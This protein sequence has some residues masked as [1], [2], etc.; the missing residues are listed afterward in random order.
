MG[1]Q[2]RRKIPEQLVKHFRSDIFVFLNQYLRIAKLTKVIN[3][4]FLFGRLLRE[5]SVRNFVPVA[6]TMTFS[7]RA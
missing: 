5:I 3:M 2:T 4:T 1:D 7:E 6:K